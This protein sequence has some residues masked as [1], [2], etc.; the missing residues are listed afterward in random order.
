M[1]NDQN[2][3]I[4]KTKTIP[5]TGMSC[6]ACASSVESMAA[7]TNGVK[8][9]RVNFATHQLWITY[10]TY[11]F[12]PDELKK[13]IQAA[14]YDIIWSEQADPFDIRRQEYV[15]LLH[16]TL[17][18]FALAIPLMIVGMLWMHEHW[19]QWISALLATPLVFYSGRVFH[20]KS[21][22]GLKT[23]TLGMDVL[24]S[25]S[26]LVA[27]FY[28]VIVLFINFQSNSH[29]SVHV[30]FEPAG[31]IIAFILLG[32][33]LEERARYKASVSLRNLMQLQEPY[34]MLVKDNIHERVPVSLINCG[35]KILVP[36]GTNFPLDG[37]ITEGVTTVD[38]SMITGEFMPLDKKPGDR[39]FAGTRN[40][41]SSVIIE[42]VHL[43]NETLLAVMVQRIQEAQ[44]SKAPAQQLADKV[45]AV[46]VPIILLIAIFTW[47]GW[48]LWNGSFENAIYSMVAVLIIS[49]PCAMGLATPVAIVAAIGNASRHGIL[50][51]NAAAFDR[52][53]KVNYFVIDKTGT[54][55]W[56]KPQVAEVIWKVDKPALEILYSME[57]HA[58]HPLARA[59]VSYFKSSVSHPVTFS[60]LTIIPGEGITSVYN[61]I[62]YVAG[63]S[64]L[65][66]PDA[67][68][69]I[70]SE[71]EKKGTVVY[72]GVPQRIFGWII[73]EDQVKP[74]AREF[75]E[76][77]HRKQIKVIMAT[78]DQEITAR[79]IAQRLGIHQV[80]A[81]L[82]PNEKA[83]LIQSLQK[84]GAK[85]AMVG[86][87]INDAESMARADVSI[88]MGNGSDV[89]QDVAD[90]TLIKNDLMKIVKAID[91]SKKTTRII[92]QNLFWAFGYNV[93]SIPIAAGMF[94]PFTGWQLNPMIAAAAMAFSSI[95]VVLNSLRLRS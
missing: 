69:N 80:Y 70:H 8:E 31:M 87:G 34:A 92:R 79:N 36:K 50:V 24:V 60:E 59:I 49:C 42:V 30:Y 3:N 47:I 52:L 86:D 57:L 37:V 45:S 56:G 61:G 13:N 73:F 51:K 68:Q 88:A 29:H 85:V 78:G 16:Q 48:M 2:N 10:D 7:S 91:L 55:T 90:I 81:G 83:T 22:K 19:A 9:A 27:Y 65:F 41:G 77:L 12:S 5:V 26:S 93:A 63:K 54:L 40:Q 94:Y 11:K 39:V 43:V 35:D 21:F 66:Q 18:A 53:S 44:G 62:T 95:S 67:F 71:I 6:A 17:V 23:L 32:K 38:E 58:D 64:T 28:S 4:L 46:F 14:G 25:M 1:L 72:F 33:T 74:E 76:Q 20:L 15:K 84:Q 82:L 89:A 75:I